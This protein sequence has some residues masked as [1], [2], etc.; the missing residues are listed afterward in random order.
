MGIYLD[1]AKYFFRSL[2]GSYS[3][4]QPDRECLVYE[5]AK[6]KLDFEHFQSEIYINPLMDNS[7][8]EIKL[9][10]VRLAKFKIDDCPNNLVIFTAR[11]PSEEFIRDVTN[12]LAVLTDPGSRN[13]SD[14][15][16]R[17]AL[18]LGYDKQTLAY[19]F[20][21]TQSPYIQ[22][23][24]SLYHW[25]VYRNSSEYSPVLDSIHNFKS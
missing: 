15:L 25:V 7:F 11:N 19:T 12:A 8:S 10:L 24:I 16:F 18:K 6:R 17:K 2:T 21:P 20:E 9:L 1:V 4:T 3:I 14:L 23:Q 13:T 5:D 22:G